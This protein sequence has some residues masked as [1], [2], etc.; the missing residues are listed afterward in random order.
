MGRR[1]IG[2]HCHRRVSLTKSD[3]FGEGYGV[4]VERTQPS[5]RE[6]GERARLAGMQPRPRIRGTSSGGVGDRWEKGGPLFLLLGSNR[7]GGWCLPKGLIEGKEDEG[8]PGVGEV[9]EE[10][11]GSRA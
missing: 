2:R 1:T 9:K 11:G 8:T 7:R 5:I 6:E 4:I 3:E 10:D